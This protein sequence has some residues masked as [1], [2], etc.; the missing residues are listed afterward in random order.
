MQRIANAKKTFLKVKKKL[1]IIL[2]VYVGT[3][4]LIQIIIIYVKIIRKPL[5]Q[6]L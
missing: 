1:Y 4:I 6:V 3:R 5:P 2:S